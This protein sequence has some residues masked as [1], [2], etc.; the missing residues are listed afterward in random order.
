MDGGAGDLATAAASDAP[1]LPD[2]VRDAILSHLLPPAPPLPVELLS[3]SFIERLTFL[4]PAED[5]L[6]AQLSPF[7]SGSSALDPHPLASALDALSGGFRLLPTQY[8]FDGEMLLARSIVAPEYGHGQ[9]VHTTFEHDD[10]RGWT[11]RGARAKFSLGDDD[12]DAGWVSHVENVSYSDDAPDDY[13]AGFTPPSQ[14]AEL[15]G[16]NDEDDY[17]AQYGAGA[18]PAEPARGAETPAKPDIKVAGPETAATLSLLLQGLVADEPA[19]EVAAPEPEAAPAPAPAAPGVLEQKIR[20][21]V[22]AILMRAWSAYAAEQ[23]AEAAAF[24][25]LRVGRE[26]NDR[27]SWGGG[28]EPYV[29]DARTA[30]MTARVE[31]A[32]EVYSAVDDSRDGFWRLIEDAI[33]IHTSPVLGDGEPFEF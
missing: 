31:A 22:R 19:A 8:S 14:R 30:V 9:A 4:P 23:D 6:D 7:P 24:E 15:P 2:T 25:W 17:W 3:R 29:F 33:K 21:K 27:P 1:P 10:K 32:K 11:Y 13:W 28:A 18:E 12:D 16:D 5:D 26:V 20:A